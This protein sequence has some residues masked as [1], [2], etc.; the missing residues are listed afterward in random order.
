VRGAGVTNGVI[1]GIGTADVEKKGR[2]ELFTARNR[3]LSGK[4]MQLHR[5]EG[6]GVPPCGSA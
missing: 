5:P 4:R 2:A 1:F 6:T 3:R